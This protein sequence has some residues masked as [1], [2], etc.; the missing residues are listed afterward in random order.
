MQ[1]FIG[2]EKEITHCCLHQLADHG[3]FLCKL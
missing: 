3:E 1:M 2:D